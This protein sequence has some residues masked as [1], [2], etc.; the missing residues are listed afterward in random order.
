MLNINDKIKTIEHGYMQMIRRITNYQCYVHGELAL[1]M[2]GL[3]KQH[4]DLRVI[5]RTN[6]RAVLNGAHL[7]SQFC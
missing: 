4:E 1:S 2:N 5:Y 7:E 6:R 3:L